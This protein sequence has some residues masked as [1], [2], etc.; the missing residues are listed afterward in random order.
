MSGNEGQF[1]WKRKRDRPLDGAAV[2]DIRVRQ[3]VSR[4]VEIDVGA[5][6]RVKGGEI[7]LRGRHAAGGAVIVPDSLRVL[8]PVPCR[9]R[10]LCERVDSDE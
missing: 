10:Y 7:L 4:P 9:H 8:D 5:V 1:L 2:V 3:G 6:R